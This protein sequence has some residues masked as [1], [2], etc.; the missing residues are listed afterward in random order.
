MNRSK[1]TSEVVASGV[2]LLVGLTPLLFLMR[3]T[4]G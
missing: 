1:I 4:H 3:K 2:A